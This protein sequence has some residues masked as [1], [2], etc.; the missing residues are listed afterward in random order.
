MTGG[1]SEETQIVK[2]RRNYMGKSD[3]YY[4]LGKIQNEIL[5]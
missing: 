5:S 1:I 3:H 4:F 2:E